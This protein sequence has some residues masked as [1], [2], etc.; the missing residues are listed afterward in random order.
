V[1]VSNRRLQDAISVSR[2]ARR[3]RN[4]S[5]GRAEGSLRA[6]PLRLTKCLKV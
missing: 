1:R 5:P 2:V 6:A 4:R 3:K